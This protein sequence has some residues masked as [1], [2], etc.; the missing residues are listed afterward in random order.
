M[1]P[2]TFVERQI[3]HVWAASM[4]SIALLFP[5]ELLLGM[6]VLELSPVLGIISGM[7]FLVK[8]GILSGEFYLAAG[9]MFLTAFLM[10]MFPKFGHTIFGVLAGA[11]FFFPGLKYYQKRLR[12]IVE[13]IRK[14]VKAG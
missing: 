14:Q 13:A 11:C 6:D 2:V 4:I 8:A 10:A 3:A 5:L 1:G 9:V 7:V 12:A